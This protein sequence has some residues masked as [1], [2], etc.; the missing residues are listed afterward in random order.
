[1]VN[2]GICLKDMEYAKRI[3]EYFNRRG[4]TEKMLAVTGYPR[5]KPQIRIWL[6]DDPALCQ[7]KAAIFLGTLE[8]AQK[9]GWNG[10]RIEPFLPGS[11]LYREC[12][13]VVEQWE[14]PQE[15]K[16]PLKEPMAAYQP[17]F[18]AADA[19]NEGVI[20]SVFSP[21]GGTG[22]TSF[23][24][25]LAG[26]IAALQP[27]KNVLY[28]N[29]EGISDWRLH[30]HS[31]SLYNLSD[32][33]YRMMME[34]FS[35]EEAKT[36]LRDMATRQYDHVWFLEPCSMFEDLEVLEEE[37]LDQLFQLLKNTFHYVICD[38]NTVYHRVNQQ[39]LVR[40]N[41]RFYMT[42]NS[43]ASKAKWQDF[44][45]CLHRNHLET[46]L[47]EPSAIMATILKPGEK[48]K[49]A[50]NRVSLPVEKELYLEKEGLKKIRNNTEW[51]KRIE[52][53]TREVL[54][55]GE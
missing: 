53:L 11:V 51:Y 50:A 29:L 16:Q 2:V 5:D 34:Q 36:V 17:A 48:A 8:E 19:G 31:D 39:I 35:I 12:L 20:F 18:T 22:K 14:H 49:K 41:R 43:L 46:L 15:P 28:L 37:E 52:R 24:M 47:E 55:I 7:G 33:L 13:M 38:L 21:I 25:S 3:Q 32:F 30:F 1:M 23:A 27:E 9:S 10:K 42:D 26:A 6:T 45:D 54:M 4:D 40:S 44:T